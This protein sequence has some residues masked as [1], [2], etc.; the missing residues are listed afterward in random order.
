MER[1]APFELRHGTLVTNRLETVGCR[2]FIGTP[3][4]ILPL[5]HFERV[6]WE[7]NAGDESFNFIAPDVTQEVCQFL[8]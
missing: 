8:G 3:L 5:H 4:A 7:G 1:N 2:D 6:L